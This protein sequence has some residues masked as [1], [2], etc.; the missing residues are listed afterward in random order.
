MGGLAPPST[1]TARGN[2]L[3]G[4]AVWSVVRLVMGFLEFPC[5]C[6]SLCLKAWGGVCPIKTNK[7]GGTGPEEGWFFVREDVEVKGRSYR[8]GALVVRHGDRW[9]L[10]TTVGVVASAIDSKLCRTV[11]AGLSLRIVTCN[12]DG[13]L[14]GK[15]SP[16]TRCRDRCRL[17]KWLSLPLKARH[18]FI[19]SKAIC[20][21]RWR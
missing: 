9:H 16:L 14:S 7:C 13:K 15:R 5:L 20:S 8:A 11:Y 6:L 19:S 2:V 1:A 18:V 3:V 10:D 12:G 17:V 4:K 21:I